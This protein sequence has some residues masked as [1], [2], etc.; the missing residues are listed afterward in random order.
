MKK[1]YFSKFWGVILLY[2]IGQAL[3]IAV[4]KCIIPNAT[5]SA[6]AAQAVTALLSMA[7]IA[8]DIRE[9]GFCKGEYKDRK[10]LILPLFIM[11]LINFPYIFLGLDI[12]PYTFFAC[13]YIGLMEEMIFRGLLYS[14]VNVKY[15]EHKAI[16]I[17]SIAFG[18]I[19]LVNLTSASV[20]LT[21]LQVIYA[22]AIGLAFAVVR[23][24]TG[25]LIFPVIVHALIDLLGLAAKSSMLIDS[26]STVILIA[27]AVYYYWRYVIGRNKAVTAE[28][29]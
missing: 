26:I 4:F 21:L 23:A 18:L 25:S 9:C 7:I 12:K 8:K 6:M 11:P 1:H 24:K 28:T 15:G 19:H 10:A 27:I 2:L 29:V 22:T 3:L 20:G 5:L 17:S 16:I 13:I 14:A